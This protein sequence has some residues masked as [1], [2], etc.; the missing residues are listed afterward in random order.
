MN[1][2]VTPWPLAIVMRLTG[3]PSAVVP[4]G[5]V[6]SVAAVAGV[7][8]R[9][10]DSDARARNRSSLAIV[11]VSSRGL[12]FH[13][14]GMRGPQGGVIG[15]CGLQWIYPTPGFRTLDGSPDWKLLWR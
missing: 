14:C 5:A 9:T 6:L 4:N 13:S 8:A 1:F 11:C 7:A 12:L 2:T 10:A 3:F 15:R